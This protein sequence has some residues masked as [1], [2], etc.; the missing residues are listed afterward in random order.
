MSRSLVEDKVKVFASD[1]NLKTLGELLSNDSSRKIIY[2]LMNKKMYTN[3]LATKL[4]MRVSLVIH[5]LKKLEDL[6]IVEISE[7]KIKRKGIKHRFF[8]IDSDIFVTINKSKEEI[9]EKGF[10]KRIFAEGVRFM[11]VGIAAISTSFASFS[12]VNKIQVNRGSSNNIATSSF[13]NFID[14]VDFYTIPIISTFIVIASC[15]FLILY[16]KK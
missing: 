8:K 6:R 9:E 14:L 11:V 12:M 5:H 16:S 3:E 4:D 7:E 15:L 10:L 2:H 13:T 1:D